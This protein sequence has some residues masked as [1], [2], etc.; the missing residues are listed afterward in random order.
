MQ[1]LH[2]LLWVDDILLFAPATSPT[3]S[4]LDSPV[5]CVKRQLST[6][7]RMKDLGEA[8]SFVGIQIERDRPKLIVRLH[9][10]KHIEGILDTFGMTECNGLNVP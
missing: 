5:Q 9:Q 2:L 4:A 1:D 7:Y 8:K 10:Q 6:K 3:T